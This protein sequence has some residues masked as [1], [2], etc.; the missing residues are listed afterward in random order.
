M[1]SRRPVLSIPYGAYWLLLLA[2]LWP[3]LGGLAAPVA[4]YG[5]ALVTMAALA[6][7]VNRLTA[8]GAV[9]F[10]A[11][12]SLIA[13]TSLT[14]RFDFPGAGLMIMPMYCLGQALIVL[15]WIAVRRA[16]PREAAG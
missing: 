14:D 12:D 11:S 9:F 8:V 10:V 5:L 2:A 6:L 16:V 13:A 4:I 7:G 15:S 3:D 1:R